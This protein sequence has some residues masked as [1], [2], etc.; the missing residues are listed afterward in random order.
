[1]KRLNLFLLLL[2]AAMSLPTTLQAKKIKYYKAASYNGNVENN[3]PSGEGELKIRY[4]ERGR[5]NIFTVKGTFS[6]DGIIKG[7]EVDLGLRSD[8]KDSKNLF[9]GDLEFSDKGDGYIEVKMIRGELYDRN[10]YVYHITPE[11]P[12]K[13][14]FQCLESSASYQFPVFFATTN[15][16]DKKVLYE[17]SD[18]IVKTKYSLNLRDRIVS[19]VPKNWYSIY[20]N[21]ETDDSIL[22]AMHNNAKV[23]IVYNKIGGYESMV[24]ERGFVNNQSA[25]V[26]WPNTDAMEFASIT[27]SGGGPEEWTLIKATR[28]F[29]DGSHFTYD[30]E[31]GWDIHYTDGSK[32]TGSEM[33]DCDVKNLIE[34]NSASTLGISYGTGILVSANGTSTEYAKGLLK[35]DYDKQVAEEK[36]QQEAEAKARAEQDKADEAAWEAR[37]AAKAKKDKEAYDALCKKYGKQYVDAALNFQVIVGMPE[38]LMVAQFAPQLELKEQGSSYKVYY[39]R[40]PK[41]I[42]SKYESDYTTHVIWVRNGKVSN[43]RY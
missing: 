24:G 40:I 15:G 43:V 26:S 11:T 29:G 1:M 42:K 8:K 9:K 22:Y 12:V 18:A 37:Q 10:N 23:L 32:F 27:H 30:K 20:V 33:K 5:S 34:A 39:R 13:F 4:D 38:E 21:A 35:A 7:A 25:Y 41:L 19:K 28:K 31:N 17:T 6:L 3:L 16:A 36:A 2:M 14:M